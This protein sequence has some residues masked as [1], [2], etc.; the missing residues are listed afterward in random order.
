LPKTQKHMKRL[1]SSGIA[2]IDAVDVV[3]HLRSVSCPFEDSFIC[4]YVT[5][6]L[7]EWK[8]SLVT[9]KDSN[10]LTGPEADARG[11]PFG[12]SANFDQAIKQ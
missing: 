6:E 2:A 8:W 5:S 10:P 4:G 12:K 9:G 11:S 3:D 7:G 1:F